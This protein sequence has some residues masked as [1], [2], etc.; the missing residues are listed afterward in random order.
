M[1]LP[2]PFELT[3]RVALVTGAGVGIGRATAEALARAGAKVILHC[4]RSRREAEEVPLFTVSVVALF[5]AE[6]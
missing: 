5:A 6:L 3:G 4:H 1:T 2:N